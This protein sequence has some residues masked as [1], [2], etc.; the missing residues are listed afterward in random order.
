MPCAQREQSRRSKT[1]RKLDAVRY[2][3]SRQTNLLF[4]HFWK[5][6]GVC[7]QSLATSDFLNP[8]PPRLS[9]HW[10]PLLS[11]G[12]YKKRMRVT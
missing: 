9:R 5:A 2:L 1:L 6:S 7:G 11:P 4:L 8:A 12:R 10:S 3:G